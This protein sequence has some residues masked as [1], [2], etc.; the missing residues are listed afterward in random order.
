VGAADG[1]GDQVGL[2]ESFEARSGG[3]GQVGA[4]KACFGLL[5]TLLGAFKW[6]CVP[7]I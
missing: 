7:V 6:L 1:A 4:S 5:S 2:G 3:G